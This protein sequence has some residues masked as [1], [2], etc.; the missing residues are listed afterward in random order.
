M[1]DFSNLKYYFKPKKQQQPLH[2]KADLCIYGGTSA[3]VVAAV[4]A[5][6]MGLKV[7]IAE[8]GRKLGG[9]GA[10]GLSRT[11]F[12]NKDAVG[13]ISRQFY[14][15][16]GRFYESN[17]EDGSVWYFE[18]S[19]AEQIY[20]EWVEREG[21]EVYFEQQLDQVE[22]VNGKI[23]KITMEN[24]NTFSAPMFIDA[25]YEGDLMARAGV[26]YTVGREQI[27]NTKKREMG[28]ILVHDSIISSLGWIRTKWK[29]NQTAV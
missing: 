23:T 8:F 17:E 25:S 1:S 16:M 6:K 13:G 24:G 12:G 5:S 11:D 19:R 22:K 15:E 26:S 28:F 14:R 10:G 4:Q 3:G 20:K 9:V 21:I 18:P 27:L 7:V 29:E 2:V